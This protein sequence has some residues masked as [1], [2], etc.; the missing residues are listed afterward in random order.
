MTIW[1]CTGCGLEHPDS[2][3]PPPVDGCVLDRGEVGVEERGDLGPHGRGWTTHAELAAQPHE[4]LR[5][6]HGRG[7][8]S[9]RR[10]PRFAIGHWSF[11]VR[12]AHGNL[13]WDPPAYL[14]E[15]VLGLVREL[16]GVDVIAVS[17]PHM[18]AAQVSWSHAFGRVPVLVNADDQEWVPRA[19]PVVE[20]WKDHAEPLPGVELI[21]L[22]GHMPGSSVARTSDGT[23]LVGDTISG[24]PVHPAW[25]SFTRNYPK[26]VPLSPAVVRRIVR[27]LDA[28]E[29]DRL[30]TLGGD[31][32]D[33]QAKAVVHRSADSHIR[34]AGGEFDRLT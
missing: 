9:L 24:V 31:T 5:R 20:Y 1:I 15:E 13:L 4:T 29:Y 14:D 22:G 17:H 30:Y 23:L 6:D 8:Y 27:R 34:W 11:L 7:V 10:E 26:L 18:F 32:I 2:P 33:S 12:T 19:D 28:Y 21:Q 3:E 25:V 16:G